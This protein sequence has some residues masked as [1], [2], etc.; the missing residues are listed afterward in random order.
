[1]LIG[2]NTKAIPWA[3][4][5]GADDQAFTA[6]RSLA[7][8]LG[9]DTSSREWQ[10]LS[11]VGTFWSKYRN[12]DGKLFPFYE[13][14]SQLDNLRARCR[15]V[16]QVFPVAITALDTLTDYTVG[17]GYKFEVMPRRDRVS[18][19]FCRDCE[20]VVDE[21]LE[22]TN[23]V[24]DRDRELFAESRKDGDQAVAVYDC[25]DGSADVRLIEGEY[26][27]QPSDTRAVERWLGVRDRGSWSFGIHTPEYDSETVWG[28]YVQWT[29]NPGD[30][31]YFPAC[32]VEFIKH[33]VRRKTKRGLSDLH[34]PLAWLTRHDKLMRNTAVGGA[35]QAAI[36]WIEQ[37]AEGTTQAQAESIAL[38]G[39][40]YT[41]EVSGEGGGSTRYATNYAEP[42]LV[43]GMGPA[44]KYV[45]G[46]MGAERNPNFLLIAAAIARLIGAR[47]SM[48]EY[49]IS[50]DASNANY[51]STMVAE[52]PWVK[53]TEA[54]QSR[55]GKVQC[56]ILYRVLNIALRSGRLSSFQVGNLHDLR[57]AVSITAVAPQVQVRDLLKETQRREILKRA[58][59][60]SLPTWTEEEGYDHAEE[61]KRGAKP[62]L[63]QAP[64]FGLLPSPQQVAEAIWKGYP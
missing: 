11:Q 58:G 13:T 46:P 10:L 8:E 29:P 47:W 61:V 23:W 50:G 28:Y 30:F 32:D 53:A 24:C 34:A 5:E 27:T 60:L 36:A 40:T 54:R 6:D 62:E 14:E 15:S 35:M 33:N 56:N 22:R 49:L 18:K 59:V 51:S 9:L 42:G 12:A 2:M 43:V 38:G 1:M 48:P 45:P 39:S 26:I 21:F 55:Y 63:P 44:M 17:T 37:Y 31:T 4:I 7:D 41:Y 16:G 25:G 57:Q 3:A 19:D 64:Q 20:A 52:S